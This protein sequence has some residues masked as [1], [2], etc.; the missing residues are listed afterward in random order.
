MADVEGGPDGMAS[1]HQSRTQQFRK[2]NDA[3]THITNN[4]DHA[5]IAYR[6]ANQNDNFSKRNRF[7]YNH[8][9]F[10][11]ITSDDGH[12]EQSETQYPQNF[13]PKL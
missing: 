10:D 5:R 1:V 4:L 12:D 11:F 8:Q 2:I 13:L 6:A 3:R 9:Q 7:M